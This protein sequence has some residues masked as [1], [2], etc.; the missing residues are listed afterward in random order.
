MS[1][2]QKEYIAS[3]ENPSVRPENRNEIDTRA[4]IRA[5]LDSLRSWCD[6]QFIQFE[7]VNDEFGLPGRATVLIRMNE[8]DY[9]T[10]RAQAVDSIPMLYILFP[11]DTLEKPERPKVGYG[12]NPPPHID[13]VTGEHK[14]E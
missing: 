5:G 4:T 7:V 2:I 3:F 10:I 14:G 11:N 6:T 8:A 13:P 12:A 1:E 9:E